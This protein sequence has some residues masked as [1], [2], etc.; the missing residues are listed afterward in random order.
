M[1]FQLIL[2]V[3]LTSIGGL[4]AIELAWQDIQAKLDRPLPDW[5][6]LQMREDLEPFYHKGVKIGDIEATLRGVCSIPSGRQAGLVRYRIKDNTITVTSPTENLSDA[7]IAH[8]V[9]VL[10]EMAK[11][12]V[13]PDVDF[14][15]ALWDSYD[16]PLY[17]E[18]TFCPVFTLC[19]L[20]GNHRG[21]LFP[22]FRHFGYRQRLFTDICWASERSPWDEKIPKAFWRGMTSGFDYT[23]YN[24]D[25]RPRSRLVLFAKEHP[26][27]VDA[28]FT[29][30]YSLQN[31]V[32]GWMERYEL[33]QPWCYPVEFVR[34]K[35]LV[36]ID[37][38]TFASNL[39]WQL[40]SNSAVLKSESDYIE[41][42]YKGISPYIHYVP[43]ALDL[44]DFKEQVLW[45][46]QHDQEAKIMAERGS[47]FAKEYLSNE[48]LVVYFYRLLQAYAALQVP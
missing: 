25:S 30:P 27:L 35:Y 24:W 16:N 8:V 32:K 42:F 13:L 10:E 2:G 19:K 43:Y 17:L 9:E 34:Y 47:S 21:V 40:L 6:R 29:S 22:E 37:G 20:K 3:V 38:N 28:A 39:W 33:F 26:E 4:G 48:S 45:L 1:L 5:M 44:S 7:R 14:L 41:W 12:L 18:N 23:L 36:S 46:Q 15:A 11:Q 31:D